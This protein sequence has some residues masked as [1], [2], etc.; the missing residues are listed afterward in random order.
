MHRLRNVTIGL[1]S[2]TL[3]SGALAV[4]GFT[5][6]TASTHHSPNASAKSGVTVKTRHTSL[7]TFLIDAKGRTLYLFEKD[8]AKGKSRCYHDCANDWPP[9]ITAGAPH[10]SGKVKASLLDTTTRKNGSMQVVYNGSPLY[11][12]SEDKKPGQHRGEGL[13]EFGGEW[14]V[15]SAKGHGIDT[16]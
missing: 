9:F 2:T 12:F 4:G 11:H 10:A 15:I 1:A 5:T 14:T 16:D 13:K 7:G 6:A 3:L 8:D